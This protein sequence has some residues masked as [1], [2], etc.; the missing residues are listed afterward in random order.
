MIR[1]STYL[2]IFFRYISNIS[3]RRHI[4]HTPDYNDP[5]SPCPCGA[6]CS[7]CGAYEK[8]FFGT[9]SNGVISGSVFAEEYI[10]GRVITKAGE[11]NG[12]VNSEQMILKCFGDT[13]TLHK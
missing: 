4:G 7:E 1:K 3:S 9:C 5:N 10:D 2:Q 13:Y 8:T 6:P 11:L 12:I